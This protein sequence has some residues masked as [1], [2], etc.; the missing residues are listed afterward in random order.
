[1]SLRFLKVEKQRSRNTKWSKPITNI[2]R[3]TTTTKNNEESLTALGLT[4]TGL[5]KRGWFIFLLMEGDMRTLG[6]EARV[7]PW[8]NIEFVIQGDKPC[9]SI[10]D[11]SIR[12]GLS[13]ILRLFPASNSK[14][15]LCIV[16]ALMVCYEVATSMANWTVMVI[17]ATLAWVFLCLE[18]NTNIIVCDKSYLGL[19]SGNNLN[20]YRE[21][22]LWNVN[23]VC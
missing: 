3:T 18:L 21:L 12:K 23:S 5:P 19:S 14:P 4:C 10:S 20:A 1:M 7:W 16:C 11:I 13:G 15:P 2:T 6:S 9:R 22:K 17:S 8:V